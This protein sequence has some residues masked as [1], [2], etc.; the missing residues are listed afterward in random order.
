MGLFGNLRR[1]SRIEEKVENAEGELRDLRNEIDD[2]VARVRKLVWRVG[3]MGAPP[4]DATN[5]V[6]ARGPLFTETG[7]SEGKVDP[8]SA[9][10]LARRNRGR[11]VETPDDRVHREFAERNGLTSN[12][13]KE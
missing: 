11:H 6:G 2:L 13:S 10:L 4:D 7:L 1:L 5:T 9:R 8:V 12:D 3:K